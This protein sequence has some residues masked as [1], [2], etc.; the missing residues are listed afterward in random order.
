VASKLENEEGKSW[1][2]QLNVQVWYHLIFT[3]L[4][5]LKKL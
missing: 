1:N 3:F 2:I 5:H 4:D